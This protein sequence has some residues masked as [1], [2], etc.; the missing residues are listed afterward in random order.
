LSISEEIEIQTTLDSKP[1]QFKI[2][3]SELSGH[4]DL[5]MIAAGNHWINP[6]VGVKIP[7]ASNC[8]KGC[9]TTT[10]GLVFHHQRGPLSRLR[11][12][13]ELGFDEQTADLSQKTQVDLRSNVS[14]A[15]R[16]FV[17]SVYELWSLTN[18]TKREA[19]LSAAGTYKDVNGFVQLDLKNMWK[20]PTLLTVGAGY[21]PIKKIGLYVQA[22]QDLE[23][24][25]PAHKPNVT[26]GAD[27]TICKGFVQKVAVDL[28]GK[29]ST[30]LNFTVNK[31]LSGSLLFDVSD[32]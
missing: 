28:K 5:G 17:F 26:F 29:A 13:F 20:T 32:G 19:K 3:G 18:T 27:Y 11:A 1:A 24:A 22:T 7:R 31:F 21:K 23:T 12:Q 9:S 16:H 2:K 8:L 30:A 10:L 15:Y 25:E 4:F 6:Y 14:F